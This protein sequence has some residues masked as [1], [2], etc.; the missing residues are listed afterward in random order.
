MV[1]GDDTAGSILVKL[2]TLDGTAAAFQRRYDLTA[3]A[4]L[5]EEIVADAESAVD[6]QIAQ[7]RHRDPDIWV[8]EVEDRAG[9]HLLDDP[10]FS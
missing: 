6:A 5:W 3:D 7:E 4:Y 9:R 1:H 8:V 2:N 10:G